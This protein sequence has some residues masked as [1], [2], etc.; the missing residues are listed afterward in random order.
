MVDVDSHFKDPSG[1][2]SL[3]EAVGKRERRKLVS[4]RNRGRNIF[5]GLGMFGMVGWSIAI[6]TLLGTAVGIW[7]DRTWSPPFS[8]TLTCLFL[9]VV[10]GIWVAS[11]WVRKELNGGT[12]TS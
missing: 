10:A 2:D 11:Y 7:I 12:R 8:A 3:P 1:R 6:P 4:R 9:G 5:F